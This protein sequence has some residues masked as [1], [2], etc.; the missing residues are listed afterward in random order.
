MG[1]PEIFGIASQKATEIELIDCFEHG[2][3]WLEKSVTLKCVSSCAMTRE[4]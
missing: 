3:S 4:L 1:D 2:K